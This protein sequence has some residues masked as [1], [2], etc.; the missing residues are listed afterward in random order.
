MVWT[1]VLEENALATP[2]SREVVKVGDRAL[3]LLNEK[4]TLYA[5]DNKCPHLKLSLKKGKITPEGEIVCPWHKSAFSLA[6][7][8]ATEWITWPP[9]VNQAMAMVS[10]KKPLDVFPVKIEAGSI[11]VEV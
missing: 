10:P 7:G 6:T 1:K 5:V 3:L 11:W 8:E 2:G 9:V 4:G